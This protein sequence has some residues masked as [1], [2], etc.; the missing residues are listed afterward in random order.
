MKYN[1]FMMKRSEFKYGQN[2][3][4]FHNYVTYNWPL[5]SKNTLFSHALEINDFFMP[6]V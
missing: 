6:V 1:H 5:W 2:F 4:R 3:K